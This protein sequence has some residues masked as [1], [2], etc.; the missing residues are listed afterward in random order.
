MPS[1][2]DASLLLPFYLL[3]SCSQGTWRGASVAG[4][5]LLNFSHTMR[6]PIVMVNTVKM[7]REV[8]LFNRQ[9]VAEFR[10]EAATMHHLG[11]HPNIGKIL[12]S[13]LFASLTRR[14]III[15]IYVS[16]SKIHRSL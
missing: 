9:V 11:N 10:R 14:L 1:I 3:H 16:Y 2:A 5:A 7:L 12:T 8:D 13:S 4:N 6:L 15:L